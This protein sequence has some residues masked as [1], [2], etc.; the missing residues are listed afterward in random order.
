M[1]QA[2]KTRELG[3]PQYPDEGCHIAPSCLDC[4]LPKCWY[5]MTQGERDA[6]RRKADAREGKAQH[7]TR[8]RPVSPG[9]AGRSSWVV[10]EAKAAVLLQTGQ[11]GQGPETGNNR[12]KLAVNN[13][14]RPIMQRSAG[15]AVA[16]LPV[17]PSRSLS[18]ETLRVYSTYWLKWQSWAHSRELEPLPADPVAGGRIHH[19]PVRSRG[20]HRN[21]QDGSGRREDGPSGTPTCRTPP[22]PPR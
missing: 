19:W 15:T 7:R 2:E 1:V 22:P 12:G 14:Y 10:D 8:G 20:E 9:L 4:P 5:E 16:A 18:A 6:Y 13:G 17:V 11:A 3:I 21:G